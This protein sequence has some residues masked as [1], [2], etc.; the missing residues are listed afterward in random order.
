[1]ALEHK[2]TATER[3]TNFCLVIMTI[4]VER[5]FPRKSLKSN[6][7]PGRRGERAGW[8]R[9]STTSR[10]YQ[11][12]TNFRTWQRKTFDQTTSGILRRIC[13]VRL[14]S[15]H[16]L[17]SIVYW[18]TF[19]TL[20]VSLEER[21]LYKLGKFCFENWLRGKGKTEINNVEW[22]SKLKWS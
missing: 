22:C 13:S 16:L 9:P 2:A 12:K 3:L 11:E 14:T 17:A 1:M 6:V 8:P 5:N 15:S 7:N 18:V 19:T 10:D 4:L 21:E 20:C